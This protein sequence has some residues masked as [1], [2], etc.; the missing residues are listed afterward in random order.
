MTLIAHK[1]LMMRT[2]QRIKKIATKSKKVISAKTKINWK[3]TERDSSS[4]KTVALYMVTSLMTGSRATS[5]PNCRNVTMKC[6]LS[7]T[8]TDKNA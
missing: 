6:R 5:S 8:S 3:M 7:Q 4:I 1:I 2:S